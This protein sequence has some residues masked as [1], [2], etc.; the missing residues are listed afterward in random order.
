MHLHFLTLALEV[1]SKSVMLV[2][3]CVALG[4]KDHVHTL[5]GAYTVNTKFNHL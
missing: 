4:H 5:C 2:S 3:T 1:R